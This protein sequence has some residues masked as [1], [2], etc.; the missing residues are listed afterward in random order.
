MEKGY[1]KY[2]TTKCKKCDIFKIRENCSY[3]QLRGRYVVVEEAKEW[4]IMAVFLYKSKD[5]EGAFPLI[6]KD[7]HFVKKWDSNGSAK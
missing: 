1:R 5:D 7:I 4:G 2:D 3:F 6:W